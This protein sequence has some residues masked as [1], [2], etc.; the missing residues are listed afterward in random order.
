MLAG[1]VVWFVPRYYFG[2]PFATMLAALVAAVLATLIG[3]PLGLLVGHLV[4]RDADVDTTAYRVIAGANLIAWLVPAAGLALSAITWTFSR[5]SD[6]TP[7]FYSSLGC[8]GGLLALANAGVGGAHEF[9]H[10]HAALATAQL[11]ESP[12]RTIH[13]HERCAYAAIEAW[14]SADFEKYCRHQH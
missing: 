4:S 7:T 11:S 8:I 10:R 3:Y 14:P 13:S 5:R 6:A 1:M 12:A 9:A 2:V